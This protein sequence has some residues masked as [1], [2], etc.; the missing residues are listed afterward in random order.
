MILLGYTSR[1]QLFVY[2]YF[3]CLLS[4]H[5]FMLLLFQCLFIMLFSVCCYLLLFCAHCLYARLLLF[6]HTL[7]RSL[8]TTLDLHVQIL[9]ACFYCAGVRGDVRL[10]RNWTLFLLILVLFSFFIPAIIL[11]HVYHTWLLFYSLFHLRSCVAFM[12]IIAVMADYYGSDLYLSL[13]HI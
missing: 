3:T 2:S 4:V 13:I 7:T 1:H 5:L 9:D 12:C 11:I 10:A 6:T 8:S